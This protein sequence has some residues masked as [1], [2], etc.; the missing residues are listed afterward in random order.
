MGALLHYGE[1]FRAFRKAWHR[2]IGSKAAIVHFHPLEEL[3]TRRF[4]TRVHTAPDKLV[5]HIRM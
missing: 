4:L 3:E 2:A 1:R 5:S